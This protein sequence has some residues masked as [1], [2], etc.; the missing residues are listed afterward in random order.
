[1]SRGFTPRY[2]GRSETQ[3]GLAIHNTAPLSSG[4]T[5]PEG[6]CTVIPRDR[7]N[8]NHY[9]ADSLRPTLVPAQ[10]RELPL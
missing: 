9:I 3:L 7:P 1:M 2:A 5:I 6:N 4:M 10:M 8:V